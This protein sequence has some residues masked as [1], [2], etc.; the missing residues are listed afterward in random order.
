M[1]F[2]MPT[3]VENKTFE[4]NVSLCEELGLRFIELNM[5]FPDCQLDF[6]Q[7]TERLLAAGDKAGIYYTLHMDEN[8]NVADFN[9]LVREAYLETVRQTIDAFKKLIPLRDKYGDRSQS[10]TLNIHMNHGIHM[11]LPDRKVQMYE[12]NFDVYMDN[13]KHFR[14]LCEE[15]IDGA[16]IKIAIENTDGFREYEKKAIE[17]LLESPVFCLTWD[18]G[19]SKVQDEKDMPFILSHKDKL[20]HFHMHDGST[21]PPL[22]HQ[23]FGSGQI[24]LQERFALARECQARCLIETKT[25]AALRSSVKWLKANLQ[26]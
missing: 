20:K 3:L 25:V 11:T 18:I 23:E 5:N 22:D 19:H 17:Y 26:D 9:P 15:W 16:D 6:L 7:Q 2:G 4:E 13:F 21:L 8:L 24:P 12:R 10:L 1:Q 14:Q